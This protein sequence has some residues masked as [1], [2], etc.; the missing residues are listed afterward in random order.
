MKKP[1]ILVATDFSDNCDKVLN[2]VLALSKN[3][4]LDLHLIHVVED[5]IFKFQNNPEKIKYNC[6]KFLKDHFPQ[7][8]EE[9]FYFKVGC[10]EEVAYE[11]GYITKEKLQE[12]AEKYKK[13]S[14][15]KYL[16]NLLEWN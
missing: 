15:G 9:N 2:K 4:D 6:I 11:E 16:K 5:K 10:I 13:S 12:S 3:K 1:S 8:N 7:I 14:Y